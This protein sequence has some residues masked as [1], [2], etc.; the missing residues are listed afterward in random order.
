MPTTKRP[1]TIGA[2]PEFAFAKN[3]AVVR[4]DS[5]LSGGT[6]AKF[7]TDGRSD[8]AELRPSAATSASGLVENIRKLI[9]AQVRRNPTLRDYDWVATPS[10]NRM[11]LGGHIHFGFAPD[12]EFVGILDALL[13][14]PCAMMEPGASARARKA[15]YGNLGDFRPQ[16]WGMEYR[17]L[18]TWLSSPARAFAVLGAA[19]ALATLWDN[20]KNFLRSV[21]VRAGGPLTA[22]EKTAYKKHVNRGALRERFFKVRDVLK[23]L[24]HDALTAEHRKGL[25]EFCSFAAKGLW[26]G[27]SAVNGPMDWSGNVSAEAVA[28]R[29]AE[30]KQKRA[31][32]KARRQALAAFAA[33]EKTPA[34]VWA[35]P[36]VAAGLPV[37]GLSYSASDDMLADICGPM[38]RASGGSPSIRV[39]GLRQDRDCEVRI[40]ATNTALGG[41]AQRAA[42][43]LRLRGLSVLVELGVPGMGGASAVEV[44]LRRDVRDNVEVCRK[45]LA[46]V[47]LALRGQLEVM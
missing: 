15:N 40:R 38:V 3:G 27:P 30:L 10:F 22:A 28:A 18:S 5:L 37:Q 45:A 4:A 20:D 42:E 33:S 44:G 6:T 21:F 43:A 11:P 26:G 8:T 25:V 39:I 29:R 17:V 34:S 35:N 1:V 19:H 32:S 36:L 46:V 24:T 31:E 13:A 9:A 12:A 2:D 14:V 23:D 47:A 7:G 41:H 16:P